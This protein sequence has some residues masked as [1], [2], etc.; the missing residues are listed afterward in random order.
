MCSNPCK[1]LVDLVESKEMIEAGMI[2]G[3][4]D[5]AARTTARDA[6]DPSVCFNMTDKFCY[7][8]LGLQCVRAELVG[9]ATST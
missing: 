1:A 4:L 2:V 8:C 7:I 9:A 3:F 6:K 5:L